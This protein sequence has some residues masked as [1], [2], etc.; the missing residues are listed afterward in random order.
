M[1]I[2]LPSSSSSSSPAPWAHLCRKDSPEGP[3]AEVCA[4]AA[5][6]GCTSECPT[7]SESCERLRSSH[8]VAV[9]PLAGGL[10]Y[11]SQHHE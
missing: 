1:V 7:H 8:P 2:A 5:R 10:Q 9:I 4:V 3:A 6:A 11:L